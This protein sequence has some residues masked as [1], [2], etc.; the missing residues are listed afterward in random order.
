MKQPD[1]VSKRI[2]GTGA[3]MLM[4]VLSAGVPAMAGTAQVGD[5]GSFAFPIQNIS[6]STT[7]IIGLTLSVLQT[8][9]WVAVDPEL[10]K[11]G[12]INVPPGQI[13]TLEVTYELLN[14]FSPGTTAQIEV[15]ITPLDGDTTPSFWVWR[16]SSMDGFQTYSATCQDTDGACGNVLAADTTPPQTSLQLFRPRFANSFGTIYIAT[17]T[18]ILV[19][20]IDP[21]VPG[22]ISTGVTFIGYGLDSAATSAKQL[23]EFLG[24]FTLQPGTHTIKYGS[25]DS[26]GNEEALRSQSL[27]VDGVAPSAPGFLKAN[28]SNPSLWTR[29][30]AF[31]MAWTNPADLSGIKR[32]HYRL[33]SLGELLASAT[34][35]LNADF[36]GQLSNGSNVLSLWLEDNVGN[37]DPANAAT[38]SLRYDDILPVSTV[39]ALPLTST[40]PVQVQFVADDSGATSVPP[41]G[42]GIAT[43]KLWVSRDTNDAGI[44]GAWS[45]IATTASPGSFAYDPGTQDGALRFYTQAADAAGN[46]ELAPLASSPPKAETFYD[47][48]PP[49]LSNVRLPLISFAQAQVSWLTDDRTTGRVEYGTTTSFGHSRTTPLGRDHLAILDCSLF[50]PATIYYRITATNRTGLTTVSP[51]SSFMTP[52][53]VTAPVD[54]FGVIDPTK[55]IDVQI[56]NPDIMSAT[57]TVD[58]QTGSVVFSTATGFQILVDTATTGSGV[59]ILRIVLNGFT[60]ETQFIVDTAIRSVRLA[61]AVL[62]AAGVM[63]DSTMTPGSSVVEATLGE[64]AQEVMSGPGS[65][66]HLGFYAAIDP[67]APSSIADLSASPGPGAGQVSLN[68]TAVGDDAGVGTAMK[69]DL[70]RST[71]PIT[72]DADFASGAVVALSTFPAMGG[73]SQRAVISSLADGTTYYFAIKA[74]DEVLNA[75]P[76]AS[77]ASAK[78]LEVARSADLTNGRPTV[79]FLSFVTGVTVTQVSTTTS[80]PALAL[81]TS[82]ASAQGLLFY[83]TLYDIVSPDPSLPG[84]A[85]IQFRYLDPGDPTFEANLRVYEFKESLGQWVLIADIGPESSSDLFFLPIPGLSFYAIMFRDAAAPITSLEPRG[86]RQFVGDNGAFFASTATVYGLTARDPPQG[87]FPASGVARTEYRVDSSNAP[88]TIL[89]ST[90]VIS[91]TSGVHTVQFRSVD[92]AGNVEPVRS[93][94]I[95]V[96][97]AAPVMSMV[98]DAPTVPS[99]GGLAVLSSTATLTLSFQDPLLPGGSPG[100]GSGVASVSY[101]LDGGSLT[102]ASASFSLFLGTGTHMLFF[103]AQDNVGNLLDNTTVPLRVVVGDALP[104]RTTTELGVPS[105]GADPIY[106]TSATP[107]VLRSVD[108]LLQLSDGAGLGIA[109][110]E[111]TLT[112]LSSGTAR[113]LHFSAAVS[114]VLASAEADG[115]Y[116]LSFF[117]EDVAGNRETVRRTTIAVDNTPPLT[118]LATGSPSFTGSR[119]FVSTRT[120]LSFNA[121]DPVIDAAASGAARTL[122]AVDGGSLTLFAASF[123][124]TGGTRSLAFQSF[125]RL[126][127]AEVL[128][129]ALVAVDADAP[130]TAVSFLGAVASGSSQT[131]PT[132]ADA[133][134]SAASSVLLA[135]GETGSTETASGVALTRYRLN[136]GAFQVYGGTFPVATEGLHLLEFQS[137]DRVDNEESLRSMRVAVDTTPPSIELVARGPSYPAGGRLFVSSTSVLELIATDPVSAGVAS[138]VGAVEFRVDAASTS[139]FSVFNSSFVLQAGPH[140]VEFRGRDRV[141]NQSAVV[142]RDVFV[143]T[144]PPVSI[145][146]AGSPQ[147]DLGGGVLL[148][149]P[150]TPILI[151]STDPAAGGAASGAHETFVAVD[152]GAFTVSVVTFTV[153]GE[154][155]RTLRFFARDNVLN[156]EAT[157]TIS[158]VVDGTPPVAALLSPSPAAVGIDQAFGRGLVAVVATVS[159]LHL[160]S[161]T[162]EFAAGVDA[163]SGFA[164]IAAGTAPVARGVIAR[165]DTL[166][167]S[168]FYT[169]RLSAADFLG[170][171]SLSTASVF[172]GDP[173]AVLVIKNREGHGDK[174]E[175]L[176]KPEGVAVGADGAIFVANTGKDQVLKFGPQGTLLAA[177]DGATALIPNKRG[178]KKDDDDEHGKPESITFKKPTGLAVDEDSNIYVADRNNNRVVVLSS[179]GVVLRSLGRTN[180]QGRFIPG[181]G[182]GEFNKPTGAAVSPTRIAVADRNN[183]RV[184]VLDRGFAF[185]FDIKI[186]QVA[187]VLSGGEEDDED[188][189]PFGVAWGPDGSLYVTDEGGDRVLVFDSQGALLASLGSEG[190]DLGQFQSPKGLGVSALSYLYAADRANKRVQKFDPFRNAVLAF[191]SSLGLEQPTGLALDAAGFLYLT[192][193]KN[194]RV[195]KLG[196]PAPTTVVTAPPPDTGKVKKGKMSREGGKLT[197]PDRVTV[198]VPAGALSQELELSIEPEKTADPEEERRKRQAKDEKKLVAVSEGV[199]YGPEGTVFNAPVTIT[200]VYDPKTLPAG[201]REEDLKVH[202]WNPGKSAWEEFPSVVDK[203]LR[204]VSAKTLHF[205]LYQVMGSGS[206]AAAQPLAADSSFGLK[207]A[208][209]FPNPVRGAGAATIRVQPGVADSVEVRVYDI[210]GRKVH[211][212][213]AFTDRGAFDDGNGLGAQFTYDHL[214]NVSGIGSGVYTY[215]VVARKAGQSDIRKTGRIG[216][217]K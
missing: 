36:T 30:P 157:Q 145:F 166:A 133:F 4:G 12:P 216:V 135:A 136:S 181:K 76:F 6:G 204:T 18:P 78:T 174:D 45:L 68:W 199:E 117:A 20:G 114:T 102:A 98:V 25:I 195:L 190:S 122:Y 132:N 100:G 22:A 137:L 188:N 165:W 84:G 71:S 173:G 46:A 176:D 182:P 7:N 79:E 52:P 203:D 123:S 3:L 112:S 92:N 57:F 148:V 196:L 55:P 150:H 104:P 94:V 28:G 2:I 83:S 151:I 205:S 17:T 186:G 193:R 160:S 130:A 31:T 159:D 90:G 141:G 212:S 138:G 206:V 34:N 89:A 158:L 96:D 142:A 44:F 60:Y 111:A 143:D 88:F 59:Q 118:A 80:F 93:A 153:P 192:D 149:S 109:F 49:L 33:D 161:Y 95:A 15:R 29:A 146:T 86:G 39:S 53:Q 14:G 81:A 66:L 108:D 147:A 72:G 191:G 85:T 64:A 162:L 99:P 128:R 56:T 189:G 215:I 115:L 211:E 167:L 131:V 107:I 70:R 140:L 50:S 198:E 170:A 127:N 121:T 51:V 163:Q 73:T 103:L 185:L 38:V 129:S 35:A 32:A 208:Y 154:G 155:P 134:L 124:L 126:G 91:L 21:V 178:N 58:G 120:L 63:T 156:T 37:Q 183:G 202:Y 139:P 11:L 8:P 175:L 61:R 164:A 105:A 152:N 106:V 172:I 209:A 24:S 213:S 207:A 10:S 41:T 179:A 47:A 87:G 69:Y 194:D 197:R 171:V 9:S 1:F 40:K 113:T 5:L 77:A 42:S 97:A 125:D 187:P 27:V 217:I 75:S 82:A 23:S 19:T 169:L 210:S 74:L 214:W 119:L 13:G 168:G 48:T 16:I 101:R 144:T 110:Q 54:I 43:V 201:T 116:A 65:R 67:M 200:L 180:P 62:D 26:A 177:F 184:Q